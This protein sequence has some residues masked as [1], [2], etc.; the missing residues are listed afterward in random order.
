MDISVYEQPY[1]DL[2]LW[3]FIKIDGY[4]HIVGEPINIYNFPGGTVREANTEDS[5]PRITSHILEFVTEKCI[6]ITTTGRVYRLFECERHNKP[7]FQ[8]I[9]DGILKEYC[10]KNGVDISKVELADGPETYT[11]L[12]RVVRE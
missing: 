7:S 8:Q 4:Y 11:L 10:E 2:K 12:Y 9:S 3:H 5:K 6:A 1:I